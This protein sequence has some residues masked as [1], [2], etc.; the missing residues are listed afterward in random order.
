[1]ADLTTSFMGIRMSSPVVVGASTFSRKV[2]KIKQA[3]ELGAGGLVIYSLFQEQIELEAQELKEALMIG[4]EHF[5]ESLT[6]F[7]QLD[8]SGPREHIMWVEKARKEVKFPLFGSLNATEMGD[9]TDYAKQLENAGCDGLELNLYSVETD[10]GT[11]ADDVEE[12]RLEVVAAVKGAVGIPVAAKIS[13]WY[14]ATANF[15]A[16][17]VEAGADGV[18]MFNRFYQPTIDPETEK[19]A[20]T[21]DLSRPEDTRL[22]LR[23]IAILSGQIDADLAASTGI[24]TGKD[25]ARQILAGAKAVQTVSALYKNG[26]EH[27]KTLNRELSDWMDA[28]G[29]RFIDEFRGSLNQQHVADLYG[30]ERAQY[31]RILMGHD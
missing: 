4:S 18:V 12:Q 6:Y 1:M 19:L 30:F 28:K 16:R 27:V 8:H 11:T 21:L 3:E 29:Y 23:W 13:P 14:T 5:P 25:V 22:P 2:D 31:I 10:P 15:V 17:L 9:W 7:P 20:S 26:L 24:H